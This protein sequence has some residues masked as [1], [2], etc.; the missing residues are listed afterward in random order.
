MPKPDIKNVLLFF[1]V[2]YQMKYVLFEVSYDLL[3][4]V[5]WLRTEK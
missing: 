5:C 3:N 2:S 4:N 1:P